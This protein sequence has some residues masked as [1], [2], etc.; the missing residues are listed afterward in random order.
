M[1]SEILNDLSASAGLSQQCRSFRQQRICE[2]FFSKTRVQLDVARSPRSDRIV[3]K[4]LVLPSIITVASYVVAYSVLTS[5]LGHR[6]LASGLAILASVAAE[7][8]SKPPILTSFRCRSV[9]SWS[10]RSKS[11]GRLASLF[12]LG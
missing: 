3:I 9:G 7:L 2:S 11:P 10:V 4:K 5:W 8:P 6:P 12:K 1:R